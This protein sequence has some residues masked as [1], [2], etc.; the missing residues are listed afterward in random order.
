[1]VW[2]EGDAAAHSCGLPHINTMAGGELSFTSS[3]GYGHNEAASEVF[4]DGRPRPPLSLV[5][6]SRQASRARRKAVAALNSVRRE[7]VYLS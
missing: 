6:A 1:M 4:H 2:R 3:L 7:G 5:A